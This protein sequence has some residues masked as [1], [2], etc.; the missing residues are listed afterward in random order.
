MALKMAYLRS[1]RRSRRS[2][3]APLHPDPVVSSCDTWWPRH[4]GDPAKARAGYKSADLAR[5]GHPSL[6]AW[7]PGRNH[8]CCCGSGRKYKQCRGS[9]G[10]R[11]E[12]VVR[13]RPREVGP[14]LDRPGRKP[15]RG[16]IR[17]LTPGTCTS[18]ACAAF[19]T[20]SGTSLPSKRRRNLEIGHPGPSHL[21][22]RTAVPGADGH[23]RPHPSISQ[24]CE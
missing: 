12:R 16:S 22:T 15:C 5:R 23:R 4:G 3:G 14:S 21:P 7:P 20:S 11:P 8:R 2:G 19:R 6:I 13:P 9:A 17:A 24:P 10:S 1:A 18:S